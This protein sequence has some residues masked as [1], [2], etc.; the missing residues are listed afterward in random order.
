MQFKTNVHCHAGSLEN[1]V[2]GIDRLHRVHC[3]A[4]SLEKCASL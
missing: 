2:V 4:G 1:K 3:H